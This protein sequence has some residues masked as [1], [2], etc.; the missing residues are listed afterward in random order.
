[1]IHEATY[2]LEDDERVSGCDHFI[3]GP[4]AYLHPLLVLCHQIP[5]Q[6]Q[7]CWKLM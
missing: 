7:C 5:V 2:Q 1:M 6:N 4:C 3:E